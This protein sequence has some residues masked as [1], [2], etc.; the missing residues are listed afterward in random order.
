MVKF[1]RNSFW[2][3]AKYGANDVKQ[4]LKKE[5]IELLKTEFEIQF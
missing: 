1:D 4:K 2:K 3:Y 5:H